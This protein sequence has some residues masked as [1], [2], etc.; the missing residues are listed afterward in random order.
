MKTVLLTVDALRV[1]HLGQYGYDRDTMPVVDR[2]IDN[3]TR[4]D[5]AFANGTNT[6]VSL[7]SLLASQY[8]GRDA[9]RDGPNVATA[10]RDDGVTTAGFHSNA[11]FANAVGDVAGFETYDDFDVAGE[12]E[13]KN[14][15]TIVERAY[16]GL[17]DTLRPITERL[18][19]REYAESVQEAIFPT[20][21]VHEFTV[22]VNA[23][24]LT[25]EVIE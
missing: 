18:G 13:A 25:D 3:G 4:F 21:L 11:L 19:V 2:L 16:N 8:F 15:E 24:Q 5:S 9:T 7:P 12:S 22:Y 1:D 14:T 6:G 17:V 23:A 20:T 10:I